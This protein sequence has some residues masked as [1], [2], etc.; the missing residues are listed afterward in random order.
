MIYDENDVIRLL[1]HQLDSWWPENNINAI[2]KAVPTVMARLNENFSAR[3]LVDSNSEPEFSPYHSV[4]WAVFL[5]Q[6]SHICA[7]GGDIVEADKVYY[8]N[9][10]MNGVDWYHKVKL[11][12]HFFAEHPLGSVLGNAS[13]GDYLFV[14][15]GTTVGGN[16]N[17]GTIKYPILGNNVL[18]YANATILGD[19]HIGN[20]VIIGADTYLLN[21]SVPDNCLVFGKS[22]NPVIKV[23]TEAYIK[24]K[25]AHIWRW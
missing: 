19:S 20:N 11:P 21:E 9:K 25:T 7:L 15:Q 22:P 5:Y 13:Y 4:Q 10:I 2:K 23:K 6:V 12:I 14:Y 18:M 16:R 3:T 24:E 1:V 17:N 8:L